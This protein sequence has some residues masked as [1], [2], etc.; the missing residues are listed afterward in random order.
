MD[1]IELSV[2]CDEEAKEALEAY[3]DYIMKANTV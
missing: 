1:H 3:R 2:T